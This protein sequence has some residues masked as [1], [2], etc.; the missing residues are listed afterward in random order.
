[1]KK[2]YILLFIFITAL[3]FSIGYYYQDFML[4]YN[5]FFG[6]DTPRVIDDMTIY[7]ANHH[8]TRVH[9]LF[10]IL[11]NPIGLF[12]N[13]FIKNKIITAVL[14]N[15]IFGG[16]SVIL[17]YKY[18][19]EFSI[20][21]YYKF[22]LIIIYSFS[23][24]TLIYAGLP[25]TYILAACSLI[26]S[27]YLFK[28]ILDKIE[29]K[30]YNV[31]LKKYFK[32]YILSIIF[33]FGVTITNFLP[34]SLLLFGIFIKINFK[35]LVSLFN[36]HEKIR[37]NKIKGFVVVLGIALSIGTAGTVVQKII[38]RS[39]GLFF[40][41]SMINE[42]SYMSIGNKNL[43]E[44]IK[45]TIIKN[46]NIKNK[47]ES[48]RGKKFNLENIDK[49]LLENEITFSNQIENVSKT[50][51]YYS[52]ISPI[53]EKNKDNTV[54]FNLNTF[55][56][57]N[58][59]QKNIIYIWSILLMVSLIVTFTKKVY[60][61]YFTLGCILFNFCLH[62]IYGAN[63]SFIYS[64]HVFFLYIIL[65]ANSMN[66]IHKNKIFLKIM[67]IFLGIISLVTVY[68]NIQIIIKLKELLN[69]NN[70]TLNKSYPKKEKIKFFIFGMGLREKYIFK[71]SLKNET[72]ELVSYPQN[73]I[74]ISELKNPVILPDLY[75]VKSLNSIGK[76]VLIEENKNG[77]IIKYDKKI[78]VISSRKINI[79]SFE[80][81][82]HSKELKILFNEVMVNITKDGPVPN[83]LAYPKPWYR[84]AAIVAMVLEKTGNISEIQNWI[85][86]ISEIYDENNGNKE[87]DNLGQVLYL[88][89]FSNQ[90]KK[91]LVEEV[92]KEAVQLSI[93]KDYIEGITDG[94]LHPVYQTTWLKYG[95]EKLNIDSSR[96]IIPNLKDSYSTLLWFYKKNQNIRS[97]ER[98]NKRWPYLYYAEINYYGEKIE[99]DEGKYPLSTE[100]KPSAAN[101][102]KMKV[103]D[104]YFSENKLIVP[105]SWSAAE[106]FLYLIN[107]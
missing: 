19:E 60:I 27:H 34:A 86:N 22:F 43:I 91:K 2:R 23:M 72:F 4:K 24:S 8:R 26:L 35:E 52:L 106:M 105:H 102:E 101:F 50:L 11:T 40:T 38:Y 66:S 53:P 7:D 12:L 47:I 33:C 97:N 63:E 39:S 104:N 67:G 29:K 59:S 90:E 64:A 30:E 62:F 82:K 37:F 6:A 89:S 83:F 71:K 73:K 85:N 74:I 21:N 69:S 25:E 76:E 55:K 54:V 99:F 48:I 10:V 42:A 17:L 36:I 84:D 103:L 94:E 95:M 93:N 16:F 20:N 1:M 28:K 9:P 81:Y 32:I 58:S 70:Y 14:L 44:N 51:L 96:Y 107:N 45:D 77:I 78:D 15:S 5:L 68:N 65:I 75:T 46:E 80:K 49:G 57:Y 92:L 13:L 18:L 87:P 41:K 88:L 3:Y 79:P 56:K 100:W 61:N 98:F 31:E